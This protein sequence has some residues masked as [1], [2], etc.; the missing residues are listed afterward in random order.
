MHGCS[1]LEQMCLSWT[2]YEPPF[3]VI[4]C[5][6]HCHDKLGVLKEGLTAL[7]MLA[8]RNTG[9]DEAR[10][11]EAIEKGQL[12]VA[13]KSGDIADIRRLVENQGA[14]IHTRDHVCWTAFDILIQPSPPSC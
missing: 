3:H 2:M 10:L 1:S 6:Q 13:V 14:D 9:G 12:I 5:E 7:Q 4:L 11:I 8:K